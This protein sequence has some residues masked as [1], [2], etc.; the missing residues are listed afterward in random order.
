MA[1][2]VES[3]KDRRLKFLA[4]HGDKVMA[5]YRA[6]GS[7]VMV[8]KALKLSP[9]LTEYILFVKGGIG[10]RKDVVSAAKEDGKGKKR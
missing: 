8:E 3:A 7:A 6:V 4:E 9:F 2:K 10:K 5:K 1:K